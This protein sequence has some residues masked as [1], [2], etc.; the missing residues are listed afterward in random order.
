MNLHEMKF[1]FREKIPDT[2]ECIAATTEECS[3][4]VKQKLRT[5][6][7]FVIRLIGDQCING[8]TTLPPK[9]DNILHLMN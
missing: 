4:G 1:I 7:N 5:S 3:N 2:E 6:F 9:Y 8:P